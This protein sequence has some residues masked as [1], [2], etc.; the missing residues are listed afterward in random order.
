MTDWKN[1]KPPKSKNEKIAKRLIELNV[2]DD[3]DYE[4]LKD[5]GI[6]FLQDWLIEALE[7]ELSDMKAKWYNAY[8]ENIKLRKKLNSSEVKNERE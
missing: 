7:N 2:Y 8:S 4:D 5:T 1:Y 6:Y 3:S